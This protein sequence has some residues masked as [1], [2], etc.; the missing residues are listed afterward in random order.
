MNVPKCPYPLI[1]RNKEGAAQKAAAATHRSGSHSDGEVQPLKRAAAGP[2]P[3]HA[4]WAVE[5][6]PG[7]DEPA[8]KRAKGEVTGWSGKMTEGVPPL[9]PGTAAEE[10]LRSEH[11][12]PPYTPEEFE[13]YLEELGMC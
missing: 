3:L 1:S 6:L 10:S 11:R 9:R 12:P 5:H 2:S 8:A 13:D 7:P 4:P